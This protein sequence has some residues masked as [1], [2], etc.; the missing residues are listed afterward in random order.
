MLYQPLSLP[1][2]MGVS[3]FGCLAMARGSSVDC[4]GIGR[5]WL[6]LGLVGCICH[7]TAHNEL[8]SFVIMRVN[9]TM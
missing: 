9:H 6:T 8:I 4:R 7:I 1:D 3:S 5:A 2:S